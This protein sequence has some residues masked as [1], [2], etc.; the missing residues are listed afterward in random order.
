MAYEDRTKIMLGGYYVFVAARSAPGTAVTRPIRSVVNS[1]GDGTWKPLGV[2]KLGDVNSK[3]SVDNIKLYDGTNFQTGK[4]F[5]VN[6]TSMESDATK[7]SVLEG[8]EA[9]KCD[10][11]CVA[12][13]GTY[14]YIEYLGVGITVTHDDKLSLKE[15]DAIVIKAEVMAQ[16]VSDI[17]LAG[18][19]A[20]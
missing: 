13:D 11:L 9:S 15:P 2:Y 17:K 3:S 5:E 12:N 6:L 4:N 18:T 7:L 16:Q 20:A 1:G 8:F 14:R 10:I 19:I